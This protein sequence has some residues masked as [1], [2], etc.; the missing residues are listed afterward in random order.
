MWKL[1][2]V[3]EALL[4]C[5][6]FM[7]CSEIEPGKVRDD[8]GKSKSNHFESEV[9]VYVGGT[10]IYRRDLERDYMFNLDSLNAREDLSFFPPVGD[11][12]DFL[13]KPLRDR[14]LE[15][16]IE[17]KLLFEFIRL[18]GDLDLT[19]PELYTHCL[20][21]WKLAM[22]RRPIGKNLLMNSEDKK[23][24]KERICELDII[25]NY[26]K[27]H[28]YRKITISD[29]EV[30]GYFQI[31]RSEFSKKRRV[32]VQQIVLASEKEANR[33]RAMIRSD[34]FGSLA[35]EYSITPE[36][37]RAGRLTPFSE[38]EMPRIF[39]TAF[40]M[41]VGE[42]R[43]VLK[44]TY[45]FHIIKLEKKLPRQEAQLSDV[46]GLIRQ[47]IRVKKEEREYQRW[48]EL[49]LSTISVESP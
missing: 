41:R 33:I 9:M 40:S 20:A 21:E 7:G 48:L 24:L 47:R 14:L 44:S 26:L 49:A 39:N 17:R 10:P 15:G 3:V 37:D 45:G 32:A 8:P 36:A 18:S 2:L 27:A 4:S 31:H 35:R 23:R 11:K 16:L 13:L 42:I 46:A 29:K 22:D 38:G 5:S 25:R 19:R 12:L 1:V 34:N 28:I 43:G 6:I 30:A